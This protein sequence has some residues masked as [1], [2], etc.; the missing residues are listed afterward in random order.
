MRRTD[1][2]RY[3]YIGFVTVFT[4]LIVI[5]LMVFHSFLKAYEMAQPQSMAQSI[6]DNYIA[7]ANIKELKENY[8]LK[9]SSYETDK[10]AQKAFSNIIS[11]N[12][13]T[14]NYS[15][16]TPKGSDIC[17]YVNAKDKD[18]MQ[19]ALSKNKKPG[20]FGITGYSVDEISFIDD[21]YKKVSVTFPSSAKVTVNG[22]KIA[23]GDIKESSLPEI[24]NVD[25]GKSAVYSCT[26][27]IKNL[28]NTDV[29]VTATGGD[30]EIQKSDSL[31]SVT[32]KFD[33]TFKKNAEDFA[34]AGAKVYANYMQD[35]GSLGAVA[36]YVD[37]SSYF[38]ERIRGTIV[39]FALS[40]NSSSVENLEITD[41]T[42]HSKDIYSCRVKFV[43]VLKSGAKIY[44]D[45]F[46]KRIYL[47]ID[48]N[49]TKIIDMQSIG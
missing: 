37:T 40:F 22:K 30:F 12:K 4:L 25:F 6:C 28:I 15:S 24:K 27:E 3:F 19:I 43:H 31:V 36:K 18:V 35:A 8:K 39:V 44:R 45:N 33:S 9:I 38:Y 14:V 26:A 5:G 16:Q 17:F 7:T 2:F 21:V 11:G 32:Q 41:F 20:K 42:Q 47:R 13:L 29:K 46:H 1:R 23:K 10:N 34:L 49:G 48:K